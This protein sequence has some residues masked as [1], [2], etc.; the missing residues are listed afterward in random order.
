MAT[1]GNVVLAD[2]RHV[3]Y[4][5]YGLPD[6]HPVLYFHGAPSSRLEPLLIGED[7][8]IRHGLRII[9]PDRPGMG[10]SS[11]QTHRGFSAW[12]VDV[13]AMADALGLEKFSVLGNSGGGVYAA[14]C[15]A[16]IPQRLHSAVMVSSI[17]RMDQPQ[18]LAGLHV[19]TRLAWRLAK[20]APPLLGLLLKNVA[21]T[22]GRDLARMK[23]V[24]PQP[25][26]DTLESAG[27][28]EILGYVLREAMRQGAKGP[29][30]D[31]SLYVHPFDIRVQDIPIPLHVFH[32]M[33]DAHVPLRLVRAA[34]A[35][36]PTARLT[37]YP[38]E[39][40]LSTLCNR[41]DDI[42]RALLD[43][44]PPAQPAQVAIS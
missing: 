6:G 21:T 29:A 17:W 44:C 7:A 24:L 14:A 31:V 5:E 38:H 18:N 15:A 1:E 20:W 4:A 41:F 37:A 10:R 42:A 19:M 27:R 28:F 13:A 23:S 36:I 3:S 25:D 40:H 35:D 32:G 9:A 2:G 12:P 8:F 43:G 39:A 22:A 30:W 26:Y 11:F 34:L 33:K 16:R